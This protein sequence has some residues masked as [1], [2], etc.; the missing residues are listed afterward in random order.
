MISHEDDFDTLRE[1]IHPWVQSNGHGFFYN[2]LQEEDGVEISWLLY[3]TREIDS[4]A[5]ADEV[6][7]VIGVNVGLC[8]KGISNGTKKLSKDNMVRALSIEVSAKKKWQTQ[9]KRL[10]LYSRSI[11]KPEYYPN[12]VRLC[13]VKS[14]TSN[15]N[16]IEKSKLDK[17]RA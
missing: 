9:T 10:Q 8:W 14:K 13:Y 1:G 17:L 12:C 4:G 16:H 6:G 2:M 5:L 3:S 11:N 15:V 7:D